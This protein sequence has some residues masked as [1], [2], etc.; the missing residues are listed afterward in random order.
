MRTELCVKEFLFL[1]LELN[2]AFE[3]I[4]LEG[5]VVESQPFQNDEYVWF[6]TGLLNFE[7]LKTILEYIAT[8]FLIIQPIQSSHSVK[9]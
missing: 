1:F 9:N 7:V 2:L 3:R 8:A 6:Y 4:C 5:D